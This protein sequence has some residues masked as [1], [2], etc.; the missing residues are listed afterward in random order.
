[1]AKSKKKQEEVKKPAIESIY[2]Q[3][4]KKKP[5]GLIVGICIAVLVL[6]IIVLAAISMKSGAASSASNAS[7]NYNVT[8][9]G[10]FNAKTVSLPILSIVLGFVDG[11]NPCAM[12]I[13]VFLILMLFEMKDRKK[14]WILGSVF[15]LT[16]ALIYLVFMVS[17]LNIAMF[18]T[19]IKIVRYAIGIFA[20]VFG[21]VNVYRFF[22]ML[23]EDDGCDVTDGKKR[24]KIMESIKK[25]VFEKTFIL[26]VLGIMLLAAGVN[27]LELLCSLGIPV[28]FT[29]VLALNNLNVVQYMIYIILYLIF[30][31]IDDFI[32]FI[33]AM[34]TFKITGISNKYTKYSH[35]IGGIFMIILGVLIMFKPAWIMFNFSESNKTVQTVSNSEF[36]L[37]AKVEDIDFVDD[38]VNIYIFWGDGCPHCASLEKY[39]EEL[40]KTKYGYYFNVYG[41]ETWYDKDNQELMLNIAD[42]V[43][44]RK[45]ITGVPFV[46][47]GDKVMVGY[48]DDED[49]VLEMIET[50]YKKEKK[51][52][53]FKK[54]LEEQKTTT[55][56]TTR[57]TQ[58]TT[59]KKK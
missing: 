6:V 11:F 19:G 42:I 59:K 47:I 26:S 22:K 34:T 53:V 17:W 40:T 49:K 7:E 36:N 44:D 41:F 9:L 24:S 57:T 39:L 52:D 2:S 4:E 20:V 56:T 23:N 51:Y 13:L 27:L 33:I 14:M 37:N 50:E 1:M 55:T 15:L 21:T 5:V 43:T 16:S 38:R 29:Q 31:M 18:L 3:E 32:V 30:F 48:G 45:N 8:M 58:I 28:V 25:I 54:Y 35:I 10:N 12:W 46:V